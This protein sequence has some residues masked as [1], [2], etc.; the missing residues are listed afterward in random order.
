MEPA[1][2]DKTIE[3]FPPANRRIAHALNIRNRASR[4]YWGKPTHSRPICF[5]ALRR[6]YTMTIQNLKPAIDLNGLSGCK[7]H[8]QVPLE[9]FA[10]AKIA[11]QWLQAR[12]LMPR[13]VT[14]RCALEARLQKVAPQWLQGVRLE[15]NVH[16]RRLR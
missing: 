1:L 13:C 9:P 10:S 7:R 15:P 16:R 2:P 8:R 6:H 4:K 14:N 11:P 5:P 12:G 3:R